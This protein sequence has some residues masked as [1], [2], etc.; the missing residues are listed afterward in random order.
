MRTGP[1]RYFLGAIVLAAVCWPPA[2]GFAANCALYARAQT[3]VELFGAAG[4]WWDQAEGRYRRGQ[5][6][7]V[8]AILVFERT[9]HMP[10]G[11]VAVVGEIVGP[12]EILVDQSNWV[13][14]ATSRGDRVIDTSPQNDWTSVA[15]AGGIRDNP[16]FGF[17]YP[18]SAAD[19]LDVY[20][21]NEPTQAEGLVRLAVARDEPLDEAPAPGPHRQHRHRHARGSA[22][23]TAHHHPAPHRTARHEPARHNAD[24]RV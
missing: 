8:G 14:G 12:R 5:K 9:G 11:H 23:H 15:V 20:V 17:I 19:G 13:R 6:P 21:G 7:A 24:H 3:G 1:A 4:G 22:A 10:S 2:P 16:T 18:D